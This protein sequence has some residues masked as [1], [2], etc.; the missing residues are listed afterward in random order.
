MKSD[1]KKQEKTTCTLEKKINQLKQLQKYTNMEFADNNIIT[2]TLIIFH[3]LK[4]GQKNMD[5]M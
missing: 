5:M 1:T 4:G 2:A 3:T